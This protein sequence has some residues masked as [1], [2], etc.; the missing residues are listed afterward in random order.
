MQDLFS[1]KM[2]KDIFQNVTMELCI[3]SCRFEGTRLGKSNIQR[4]NSR[5]G[6]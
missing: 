4:H 6:F 2:D 1:V 5:D 3:N